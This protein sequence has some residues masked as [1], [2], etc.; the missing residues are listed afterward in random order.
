MTNFPA[1][2][3]RKQW[4]L[5][6]SPFWPASWPRPRP[7]PP[8]LREFRA[9]RAAAPHFALPHVRPATAR[10]PAARDA[11]AVKL[12][13]A[14]LPARPLFAPRLAERCGPAPAGSHG[15]SLWAS[16]P[17]RRDRAYWT[18][19]CQCRASAAPPGI[20]RRGRQRRG[21]C[22]CLG[23]RPRAAVGLGERAAQM[24]GKGEGG[25]PSRQCLGRCAARLPELG[26]QC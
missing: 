25:Q 1:D 22:G 23:Q 13:R 24:W 15:A 16:R 8:A 4:L 11:L 20:V 9:A 10:A 6:A 5:F 19:C 21:R 12:Q 26:Y 3:L 14:D 2:L 17:N 7:S 18:L